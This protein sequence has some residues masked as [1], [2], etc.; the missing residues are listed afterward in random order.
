MDECEI[1][2]LILA[3]RQTVETVDEATMKKLVSVANRARSE[4]ALER[5]ESVLASLRAIEVT[6]IDDV[7]IARVHNEFFADPNATDVITF[8]HGE[9]LVS[10]ET[11]RRQAKKFGQSFEAELA[12][13]VIHGLAHLAG[14]DDKKKD[15]R[16]AMNARQKELLNMLWGLGSK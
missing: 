11:A 5:P 16:A 2:G 7:D 3:N 15:E 6:L 4:L 14:Y 8:E 12:L 1:N 10:V 13:Y 9:I